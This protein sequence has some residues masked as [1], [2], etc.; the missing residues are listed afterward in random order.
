[1][2]I[3][4]QL[5][6]GL[7][8]LGQWIWLTLPVFPLS[9]QRKDLKR[10]RKKPTTEELL[11]VI[12]RGMILFHHFCCSALLV[13]RCILAHGHSSSL[14]SSHHLLRCFNI[15]KDDEKKGNHP[16]CCLELHFDSSEVPILQW[17]TMG[18]VLWAFVGSLRMKIPSLYGPFAL[19]IQKMF[20][21]FCCF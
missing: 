13:A 17:W 1:M 7:C 3:R 10:R 15:F 12:Q 8:C 4:G 9:S 18:R 20:F 5:K 14:G 6:A 19:V 2:Q 11:Q 16:S 21:K